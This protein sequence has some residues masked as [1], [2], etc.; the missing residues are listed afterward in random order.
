MFHHVYV[1]CMRTNCKIEN[2]QFALHKKFQYRYIFTIQDRKTNQIT[3]YQKIFK[4]SYR[5]NRVVRISLYNII[6]SKL[7]DVT[8]ALKQQLSLKSTVSPIW[9]YSTHSGKPSVIMSSKCFTGQ[10]DHYN[11]VT[12]DS[13]EESCTPKEFTQRLAGTNIKLFCTL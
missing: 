7:C 5:L 2:F 13:E 12:I 9:Y 1:T 3:F 10:D 11:G 8:T 4:H 6:T